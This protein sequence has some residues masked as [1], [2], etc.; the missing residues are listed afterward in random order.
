M[1][2]VKVEERV[3]GKLHFHGTSSKS[4]LDSMTTLVNSIPSKHQL[5]RRPEDSLRLSPEYLRK[6]KREGGP[7]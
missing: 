6:S 4:A 2:L 7:I 5:G 3:G 1:S